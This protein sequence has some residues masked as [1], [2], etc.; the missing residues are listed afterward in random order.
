[1]LQDQLERQGKVVFDA[2]DPN[3]PRFTL[4]ELRDVLQE[5]NALKT[6]LI[7]LEQQLAEQQSK[8]PPEPQYVV[9]DVLNDVLN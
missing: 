5:R 3:R 2:S 4:Q 1:M 6:S 9:I 7:D 8:N